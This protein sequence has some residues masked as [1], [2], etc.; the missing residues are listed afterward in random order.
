V[1]VFNGGR[2]EQ[3]DGP[4][5]LYA[6]PRTVFVAGFVGTANVLTGPLARRVS[7]GDRPVSIRPEAIRFGPPSGAEA[8]L[9]GRLLDVQFHGPTSRYAVEVEGG[10]VLSVSLPSADG[11]GAG[12]PR[13]GEAVTLAWPREAMVALEPSS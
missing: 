5:E 3:V 4:R 1:A 10:A 6:R 7:G 9:P 2:L 12:R 13:P 11:A 8:G